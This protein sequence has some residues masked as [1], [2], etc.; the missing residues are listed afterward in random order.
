[1][2]DRSIAPAVTQFPDITL[3]VP[4]SEK[5]SNGVELKVVNYGET[6]VCQIDVYV[7]GGYFEQPKRFLTYF[8]SVLLSCG[9]SCYTAEEVAEQLDFY[10]ASMATAVADHN[11]KV[12]LKTTNKNLPMV[13]PVFYDCITTPKYLQKEL[14]KRRDKYVADN[15]VS[16]ER[17]SLI[18]ASKITEMLYGKNHPLTIEPNASLSHDITVDDLRNFHSECFAPGN[19]TLVVSGK[20]NDEELCQIKQCFEKW[21]PKAYKGKTGWY[22]NPQEIKTEIVQKDGAIQT[23]VAVAIDAV[24]REHDD[25]IPLRI[26]VTAL[27]GY[28]G[29]R[30]MMNI[31]EDKGYTY[32]ISAYLSGRGESGYIGISTEC[33]AQYTM[34]VL[35]EIKKEMA[36]L[37]EELIPADE[38]EVVR[39]HMLSSLVKYLDNAFSIAE[40]VE[41]VLCNGVYPEYFNEQVVKIKNITPEKL[42][43]MARKYLLEE[44]MRIVLAGDESKMQFAE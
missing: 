3:E 30:L 23:A 19:C 31:R 17:V 38:L 22:V 37:R 33:G 9:S 12:S 26:L 27:G 42:R 16:F 28:F 34:S 25:Y 6:D 32:G 21:E 20:V 10:G 2:L 7:G 4:M 24:S 8:E 44:K 41:L 14:D 39:S 11:I 35:D 29:S 18:A 13:L 15:A 5:L 40:Y 1:M 43:D 36:R